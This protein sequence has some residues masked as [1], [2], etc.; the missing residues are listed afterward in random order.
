[1]VM[2]PILM[3]H[4]PQILCFRWETVSFHLSLILYI[5]KFYRLFFIAR[6]SALQGAPAWANQLM[7]SFNQL[8]V[9]V[10]QV[11]HLFFCIDLIQTNL[12][13]V[14]I[15]AYNASCGDGV[16][17]PWMIVSDMNGVDPTTLVCKILLFVLAICLTNDIFIIE[18]TRT[19]QS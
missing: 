18:F 5:Y 3:S 7:N 2:L 17:R 13:T 4:Q 14:H 6:L 11:V 19:P 15:K 10:A 12:C 1:M 9:N 16:S 8:K